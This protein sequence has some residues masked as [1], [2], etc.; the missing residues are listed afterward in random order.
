MKGFHK[1]GGHLGRG[2]SPCVPNDGKSA[3]WTHSLL[4]SRQHTWMRSLIN[5]PTTRKVSIGLTIDHETKM[6][7]N[8][9]SSVPLIIDYSLLSSCD[10]YTLPAGF[11][12]LLGHQ[13]RP[14]WESPPSFLSLMGNRD[15]EG[16]NCH[17]CPH[18]MPLPLWLLRQGRGSVFP[19]SLVII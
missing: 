10:S 17:F 5:A 16:E 2:Q 8:Q 6:Y 3:G 15:R 7:G 9:A 19:V 1:N 11:Y 13:Q 12:H 4:D 18:H 14:L